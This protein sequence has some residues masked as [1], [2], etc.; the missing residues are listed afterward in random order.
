MQKLT[1][2]YF[3]TNLYEI[4]ELINHAF[5]YE[6][7]LIEIEKYTNVEAKKEKIISTHFKNKYVGEYYINEYGKPLSNNI[8]FNIAHSKG[9]V[10]F[11]KDTHPIGID[12][13]K[14]REYKEELKR[15]I[16]SDDEN[17]Y[18]NNNIN[19]YKI[20]TNKESLVKANGKGLRG[21]V[22]SIPALP[23]NGKVTFEEKVYNRKSIDFEC[24]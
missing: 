15:Y 17:E 16:S 4:D 21:D 3:D 9:M 10:V 8:C 2:F 13:E 24:L 14:I 6:K 22:K 1:I 7:D 23:I 11:V 12:I 5:L 18:I 20:W 19:F